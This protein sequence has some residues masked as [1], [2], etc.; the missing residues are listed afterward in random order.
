VA[1]G[2]EG[3][4]EHA[5]IRHVYIDPQRLIAHSPGSAG[6]TNPASREATA[7]VSTALV[8]DRDHFRVAMLEAL[9]Y[10]L[11][12]QFD[13]HPLHAAAVAHDGRAV[14]LAGESGAGKSTLA[15]LAGCAGFDVLAE[16]H[17]WIQLE[18]ELRVWGGTSRI[19]LDAESARHFPEMAS[20]DETTTDGGKRKL[21]VGVASRSLVAGDA[22]VCLLSRDVSSARLERVDAAAI[23]GRSL[24]TSRLD[25]TDSPSDTHASCARSPRGAAGDC[26]CRRIRAT[27]SR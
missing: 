12:A 19:R 6:I 25:S 5:P 17:A 13:R 26:G 20:V 22:V 14:L 24:P 1:D 7:F 2:D 4:L 23:T 9:T 3:G 16:D 21:A 18:P 27:R 10:A 15:Y 11:V 8:A